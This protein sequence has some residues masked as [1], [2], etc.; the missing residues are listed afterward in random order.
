MPEGAGAAGEG[1]PGCTRARTRTGGPGRCPH[2]LAVWVGQS[3]PRARGQSE[4]DPL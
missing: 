4:K 2:P 1:E 3:L